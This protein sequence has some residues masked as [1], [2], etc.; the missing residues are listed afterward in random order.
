MSTNEDKRRIPLPRWSLAV[1]L[2]V[3]TWFAGVLTTFSNIGSAALLVLPLWLGVLGAI[4][5]KD[6]LDGFVRGTVAGGLMIL[7]LIIVVGLYSGI[8]GY[9]G[10]W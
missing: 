5:S 10:G 7:L 2:L 1:M 8:M 4:V 9:F 6:R 3:V